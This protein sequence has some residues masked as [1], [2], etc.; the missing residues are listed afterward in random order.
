MSKMGAG[1]EK[2]LNGDAEFLLCFC[3]VFPRGFS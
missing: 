3:Q 1:F 2:L